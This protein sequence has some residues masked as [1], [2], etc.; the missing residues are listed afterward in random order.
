[1]LIGDD[2]ADDSGGAKVVG[3]PGILLKTGK[4]RS[5]DEQNGALR[6]A[7]IANDFAEAVTRLLT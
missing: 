6:P 2:L 3:I 7:M 4:F 1:M 5:S